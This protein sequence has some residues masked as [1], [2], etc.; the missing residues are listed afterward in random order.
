MHVLSPWHSIPHKHTH[1]HKHPVSAQRGDGIPVG[2]CSSGPD[3]CQRCSGK[4]AVRNPAEPS[5]HHLIPDQH[6]ISRRPH[7]LLSPLNI[8]SSMNTAHTNRYFMVFLTLFVPC[9]ALWLIIMMIYNISA[10]FQDI[11]MFLII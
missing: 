11:S 3:L 5:P 10:Y 4:C 9:F 8:H 7:Q 1:N 6:C 2:Q